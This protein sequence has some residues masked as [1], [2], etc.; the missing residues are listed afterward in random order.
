MPAS[1]ADSGVSLGYDM[2]KVFCS[3]PTRERIPKN[4]TRNVIRVFIFFD[5]LGYAGSD[6][7]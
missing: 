4:M 1:T 2:N 7:L 6:R 3:V 5:A